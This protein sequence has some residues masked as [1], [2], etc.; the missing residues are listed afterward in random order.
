MV[1]IFE[2]QTTSVD[3]ILTEHSNK[4]KEGTQTT[5]PLTETKETDLNAPVDIEQELRKIY[6]PEERKQRGGYGGETRLTNQDFYPQLEG[7][8]YHNRPGGFDVVAPKGALYPFA[9]MNKLRSEKDRTDAV[10]KAKKEAANT[11]D[12]EMPDINQP[13]INAI[14]LDS[15]V[16]DYQN[17]SSEYQKKYGDNYIFEMKKDPKVMSHFKKKSQIAKSMNETIALATGYIQKDKEKEESYKDPEGVQAAMD[18]LKGSDEYISRLENKDEGTMAELDKWYNLQAELKEKIVRQNDVTTQATAYAEAL[19]KG[20]KEGFE[21]YKLGRKEGNSENELYMKL[22]TGSPFLS[23]SIDKNGRVTYGVDEKLM[24][25]SWLDQYELAWGAKLKKDTDGN[26]LKNSKGEYEVDGQKYKPD[27]NK[28]LQTG[29]NFTTKTL[30]PLIEKLNT[31]ASQYADLALKKQTQLAEIA[32]STDV[33]RNIGGKNESIA[34][35]TAWESDNFVSA[36]GGASLK[37]TTTGE[38]YKMK[39]N[40][41]VF[42]NGVELYKNEQGTLNPKVVLVKGKKVPKTEEVREIDPVYKDVI[43]TTKPVL[44]EKGNQVY[45][46]VPDYEGGTFLGEYSD[47]SPNISTL[48][49]NK[50][51]LVLPKKINSILDNTKEYGTD[52]EKPKANTNSGTITGGKV[53]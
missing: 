22:K 51:P 40:E 20:L 36:H 38:L 26:Y 12:I 45:E 41:E 14:F 17:I 50:K 19:N 32:Y 49:V 5:A 30:N 13:E 11:W 34:Y 35:K 42:I 52:K 18:L 46:T 16:R 53:R 27:P 39:D 9:A 48:T 25:D 23:Q 21:S 8:D 44:D 47:F 2:N 37:N 31:N 10:I 24:T 6:F 1:G 3:D 15:W 4:R 29:I 43:T 28:F 7:A 33:E